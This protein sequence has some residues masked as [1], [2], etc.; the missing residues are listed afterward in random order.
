M[1]TFLEQGL[2]TFPLSYF[3]IYFTRRIM[4]EVIEFLTLIRLMKKLPGKQIF[5]ISE[6]NRKTAFSISSINFNISSSVPR[7]MYIKWIEKVSIDNLI[8]YIYYLFLGHVCTSTHDVSKCLRYLS[9]C[10]NRKLFQIIKNRSIKWNY[11]QSTNSS[12]HISLKKL[13]TWAKHWSLKQNH[14]VHFL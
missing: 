2:P 8:E 5:S 3:Y 14:Y 10:T 12:R 4:F 9:N 13:T 1:F 6:I 11:L 7:L